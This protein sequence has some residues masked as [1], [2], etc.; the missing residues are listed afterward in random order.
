MILRVWTHVPCQAVNLKRMWQRVRLTA[1]R[2]MAWM[3][4]FQRNRSPP[5]MLYRDLEIMMNAELE[6]LSASAS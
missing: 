5:E 6:K 2:T 4:I 1:P 3:K